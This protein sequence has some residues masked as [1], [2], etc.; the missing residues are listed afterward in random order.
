M[1][2]LL[3]G[4]ITDRSEPKI[5]TSI[6]HCRAPRPIAAGYHFPTINAIRA[7]NFSQETPFMTPP[8]NG[9][10]A[11]VIRDIMPQYHLRA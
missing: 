3:G 10:T 9:I 11:E 4:Q 1:T 6:I 2:A 5:K 8:S 7:M